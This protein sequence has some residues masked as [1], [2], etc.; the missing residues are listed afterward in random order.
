MR[1][2]K[3]NLPQLSGLRQGVL[4]MHLSLG[5][6]WIYP[7]IIY[8]VIHYFQLNIYLD[9][10]SIDLYFSLLMI[11]STFVITFPILRVAHERFTS[12]PLK[13]LKIAVLTFPMLL[14]SSL[15]L[16]FLIAQFLGLFTSGNQAQIESLFQDYPSLVIFQA[17]IYAPLLEEL[18]FRG[19]IFGSLR[20]HS[21][22][23]A[24]LISSLLFGTA[25]L[26]TGAS[27]AWTDLWFLPVYSVMGYFLALAYERSGSLYTPMLVHFLN[28]LVGILSLTL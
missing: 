5:Q 28:N 27:F 19:Y 18:V 25:H 14:T 23:L 24:F 17:L 9:N 2:D 1:F 22:W 7:S 26:L 15:I 6:R 10:G 21:K 20:K 4:L 16:N 3:S 12:Q 13:H 8:Q 11:L